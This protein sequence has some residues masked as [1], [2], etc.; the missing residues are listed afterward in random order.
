MKLL[1]NSLKNRKMLEINQAKNLIFLI[2]QCFYLAM[3]R[4]VDKPFRSECF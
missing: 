2:L 4:F 3:T 1:K